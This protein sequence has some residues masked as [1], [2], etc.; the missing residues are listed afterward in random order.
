M[1]STIVTATSTFLDLLSSHTKLGYYDTLRDESAKAFEFEK[2]WDDWTALSK[3]PLIDSAIRETLRRNPQPVRSRQRHVVPKNGITLPDG[4]H[5]PKDSRLGFSVPGIHFDDRFYHHPKMYDPFRFV[6]AQAS[7]SAGEFG[8]ENTST[9][10]VSRPWA[11]SS[12]VVTSNTFLAFG[13][14]RHA[15]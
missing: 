12:I 11:F 7:N 3:L 2:N 14:G 8:Q 5:L 10:P 13:H 9:D 1:D 6:T 4:H 15:W